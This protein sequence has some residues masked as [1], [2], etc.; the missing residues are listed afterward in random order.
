MAARPAV[1]SDVVDLDANAARFS[2]FSD[3][4]DRGPARRRRPRSPRSSGPTPA[5]SSG[6][7]SSISAAAPGC[8]RGGARR[9]P[10]RWSASSRVTTCGLR[11]AGLAPRRASALRAGLVARHRPA[12]GRCRRRGR[13]PSLA[14]D[15]PDADVR[16]GGP[17][18]PP[19]GRVRRP[20]LRLAAVGRHRRRPMRPGPAVGGRSSAYEERL[21]A[22]LTGAHLA[23]PARRRCHRCPS[24]FGR[25]PNRG[26]APWRSGCRPWSK[27]E[28]L[29]RMRDEWPLPL[30][31]GG[32]GDR[33]RGRRRRALHRVA[34]Q[35]RRPADAR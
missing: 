28:H 29:A 30:V 21:A 19:G 1:R 18:A 12:V 34:A 2:G 25:D 22:G 14:L 15:G 27:D 16:R 23:R 33:H 3:L 11:A 9:G 10:T 7:P 17:A 35:P 24:D 6:R 13:G 31:P 4:Y 26:P 20:R 32:G 8:R 5:A